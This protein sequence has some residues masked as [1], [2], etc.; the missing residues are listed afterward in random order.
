[1]RKYETIFIVDPDIS[2]EE[3]KPIFDRRDEMVPKYDG[4]VIEYD[5]WKIRKLAYEI[6]KKKRGYYV[7]MEYCGDGAL[8]DEIE[9][10]LRI[11]ERILKYMT[12][13]LE[14]QVDIDRIKAELA[15]A[16]AAEEAKKAAAESEAQAAAAAPP[17]PEGDASP[18]TPPEAEPA[19]AEEPETQSHPKED[20]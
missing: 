18:A 6:K 20:A 2:E 17:Q 10:L 5:H 8:V 19:P 12:V 7:R 3:R 15:E 16:E 14:V 9:R 1:M 11:D 4:L 13:Q